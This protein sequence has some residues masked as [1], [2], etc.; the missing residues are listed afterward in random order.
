MKLMIVESPNKVKKIEG[1]LGSGWRVAASVGHIRDLPRKAIGIDPPDFQLQYEFIPPNTVGGRT[2]P[3][4]KERVERL[5]A[6]ARDAEIVYL[7][8]DPDREGEAIAWHL[9]EALQLSERDYVR[10]TFDEITEP[11]I[12]KAIQAGRQID[13]RLVK[14][15]EGRR[16]LDRFVGYLVSPLLSDLLAE[17]LSAGRVQ[18]V[19]IRLVVDLERRIQAFKKTDH[20]GAVVSFDGGTWKAEWDTAPFVT[21]NAPYVLDQELAQAAS[22]CRQF[23]V[24]DSS[25]TEARKGPPSPFSTS[26]ML[27][28]A[29]VSLKLDPEVT[30]KAAQRL[31]EQGLITYIRTDGVNISDEAAAEIRDLAGAKGWKIPDTPRTFKAKGGAQEA[32]EAIRPTHIEKEEAGQDDTERALYQLIWQRTV[33]SQLADARYTV[34]EVQL[35]SAD[36]SKPFRFRATGRTLIDPGWRVLTAKDAID[37]Q[38]GEEEQAGRVPVLDPGASKAADSGELKR[39]ATKAPGRFTKA[40]LIA[41]LEKEG[42]G[43]PA[44]YASIMANIMQRGYLDEQKRFLMPTPVGITVV[45]HLVKG[46]FGFMELDFTRELEAQ[47]D[48]VAEGKSEF[49][50]VVAPAYELLQGEINAV[51]ESGEFKPRH[52]CPKCGAALRRFQRKDKATGKPVRGAFGWACT[53]NDDCRTFLDDEKGSPVEVK[54]APCPDCGKTMYRRK[55]TDGYWW[56][57]SGYPGC[58]TTRPDANGKPG[59]AKASNLREDVRCPLCD[60]P[61][62]YLSGKSAKTKKPY[63]FFSCSDRACKGTV[64]ADKNGNPQKPK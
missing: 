64:P 26:L 6:L 19:A 15:Q 63:S 28:A 32:H 46:A 29:S 47:L 9:K 42:I 40:S 30:T 58:K 24:V 59:E 35:E 12:R 62:R 36:S 54:E 16:A 52:A 50:D 39:K 11:A 7:A 49:M 22:N 4:G 44:T 17:R 60:K 14:A 48:Q 37:D 13:Y 34:N 2:F 57:C 51:R 8:T 45:D 61:T 5:R 38:E 10:V 43:R 56:A 53:G 18:S 25:S 21:E 41:R 55:G 33:A 23:S 1:Y 31:F 20:F 27:Q 3:G